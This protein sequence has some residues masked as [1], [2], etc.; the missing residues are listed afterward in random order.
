MLREEHAFALVFGWI[1]CQLR[2][3][4]EPGGTTMMNAVECAKKAGKHAFGLDEARTAQLLRSLADDIER[5]SVVL[6]S[7]STS[8]HAAHEEFA[9]RELVVEVLEEVLVS[10]PRVIKG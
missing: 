2:N 3:L 10:G 8:S 5:G 7:V 6:H 1:F 4:Y 9:V